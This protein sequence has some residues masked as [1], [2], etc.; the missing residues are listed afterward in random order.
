MAGASSLAGEAAC[1]P[2]GLRAGVM[3]DSKRVGGYCAGSTMRQTQCVG[4]AIMLAT[5]KHTSKVDTYVYT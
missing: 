2:Q 1:A 3:P 5:H 4:R